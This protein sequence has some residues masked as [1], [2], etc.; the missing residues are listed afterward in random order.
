MLGCPVAGAYHTTS[1]LSSSSHLGLSPDPLPQLATEAR[2]A[3]RGRV[4]DSPR[5]RPVGYPLRSVI[6]PHPP[7]MYDALV[8]R[9]LRTSR[10]R[11]V[12]LYCFLRGVR[13]RGNFDFLNTP[14][15]S[16]ALSRL[17][18]LGTK[19][20]DLGRYPAVGMHAGPPFP[21]QRGSSDSAEVSVSL[22]SLH[23]PLRS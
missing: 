23:V 4:S 3:E 10:H 20:R 5:P 18:I 13:Q 6:F 2:L 15:S 7:G 1:C 12:S 11:I 22:P 8:R 21:L 9:R 19:S 16:L 17:H 14:L